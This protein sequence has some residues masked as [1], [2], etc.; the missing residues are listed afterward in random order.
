MISRATVEDAPRGAALLREVVEE[1]VVTPVTIRYAM[2]T[3]TPEDRMGWWKAEREG[4]LVGWAIGGLDAFAPVRTVSFGGVIVHPEHRTIGIGSAL[5][6]V[7]RAHLEE[8]GARRM[9]S[10]SVTPI[11]ARSHSP[12]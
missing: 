8:A 6:D 3:T 11:R 9:W 2:E 4:A 12:R 10:R 5:W 1:R 7:V